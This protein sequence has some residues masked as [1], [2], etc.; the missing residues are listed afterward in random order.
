MYRANWLLLGL[1][2]LGS[3]GMIASASSLKGNP[4]GDWVESFLII[5]A[6]TAAIFAG[7][8]QLT[9]TTGRSLPDS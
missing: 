5:A 2:L 1:S 3:I 6:L 4:L 7:Q 9:G 8:L